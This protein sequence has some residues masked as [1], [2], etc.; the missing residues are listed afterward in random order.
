MSGGCGAGGG[1]RRARMMARR[2]L[3]VP[4]LIAIGSASFQPSAGC[5]SRV[6]VASGAIWSLLRASVMRRLLPVDRIT[7]GG[8]VVDERG[9]T[10]CRQEML[11][12]FK[13]LEFRLGLKER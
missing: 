9:R 4:L 8:S 3:S 7:G 12:H 5:R 6:P 11:R 2:A 13:R 10:P 1:G